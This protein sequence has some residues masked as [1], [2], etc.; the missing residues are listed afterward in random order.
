MS[1]YLYNIAAP[2]PA[3]TN[4][5]QIKIVGQVRKK[6]VCEKI[7]NRQDKIK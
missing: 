1:A 5:Q 3:C 6:K 7:G 4:V 2:Y